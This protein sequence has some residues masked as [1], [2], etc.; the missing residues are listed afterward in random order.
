MR[1]EGQGI[2]TALMNT[3]V[4]ANGGS[5][6]IIHQPSDISGRSVP[7]TDDDGVERGRP[8]VPLWT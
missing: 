1:R 2:P 5:V 4:G 3:T 6:A 7:N 8:E